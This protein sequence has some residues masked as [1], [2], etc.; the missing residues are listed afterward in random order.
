MVCSRCATKDDNPQKAEK[1]SSK[2]I[3]CNILAIVCGLLILVAGIVFILVMVFI[4]PG[5]RCGVDYY[6]YYDMLPERNGSVPFLNKTLD[7][8]T[9]NNITDTEVYY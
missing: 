4:P 6:D 7:E 8:T 5:G 3:K 1:F 9:T 2:A